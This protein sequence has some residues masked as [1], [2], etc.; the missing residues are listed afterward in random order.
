MT[1]M[2]RHK[3][4]NLAR[5]ATFVTGRGVMYCQLGGGGAANQRD[6]DAVILVCLMP[7]EGAGSELDESTSP[8]SA[9][10]PAGAVRRALSIQ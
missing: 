3:T 2:Y 4:L 7:F 10:S 6:R 5:K 1:Q 9:L 8:N